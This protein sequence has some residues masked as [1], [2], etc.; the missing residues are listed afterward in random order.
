MGLVARPADGTSRLIS[1]GASLCDGTL[2]NDLRF[3]SD[4]GKNANCDL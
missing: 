2:G 4:V 1:L 3:K